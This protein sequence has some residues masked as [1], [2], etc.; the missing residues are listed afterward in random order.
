M[1]EGREGFMRHSLISVKEGRVVSE[2]A[3]RPAFLTVRTYSR[4]RK[5][6]VL[7]RLLHRPFDN[8]KGDTSK[9]DPMVLCV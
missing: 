8:A 4:G 2:I 6:G 9:K 1:D 3:F 7:G 5:R